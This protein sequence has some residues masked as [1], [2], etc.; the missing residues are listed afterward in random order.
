MVV[1]CSCIGFAGGIL[2]LVP[3]IID[4]AQ[5]RAWLSTGRAVLC[6]ASIE[7]DLEMERRQRRTALSLLLF[8]K[9]DELEV[10]HGLP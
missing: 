4:M 9:A 2:I 5:T 3:P 7:L 1:A 8:K 6:T 10:D